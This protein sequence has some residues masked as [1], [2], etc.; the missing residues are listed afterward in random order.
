VVKARERS[1]Q[2]RGREAPEGGDGVEGG[3]FPP[4][5]VWSFWKNRIK[6][7]HCK[8]PM[9][10]KLLF[11]H[12]VFLMGNSYTLHHVTVLTLQRTLSQDILTQTQKQK[13]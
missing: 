4:S 10:G 8:G 13:D 1:D 9:K 3:F 5:T 11:S 2:A 6:I 12:Y 7:G